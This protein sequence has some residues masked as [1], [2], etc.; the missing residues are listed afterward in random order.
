MRPLLRR[1]CKTAAGA[2]LH[3]TAAVASATIVYA[4]N[5]ASKGSSD[6][7]LGALNGPIADPLDSEPGLLAAV[8]RPSERAE[9]AVG[10]D[11]ILEVA[12]RQA[13]RQDVRRRQVARETNVLEAHRRAVD[14]PVGLR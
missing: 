6:A 12:G 2:A 8:G 1:T 4:R 9:V 10:A 11:E 7:R 3:E 13:S 14:E 5:R